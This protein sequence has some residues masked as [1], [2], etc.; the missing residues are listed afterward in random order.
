[1]DPLNALF[2]KLSSSSSSASLEQHLRVQNYSSAAS[3]LI[4]L[5]EREP[6]YEESQLMRY[7]SLYEEIQ[8]SSFDKNLFEKFTFFLQQVSHLSAAKCKLLDYIQEFF[9]FENCSI[10]HRLE[11]NLFLHRS[12][13]F[14]EIK[15]KIEELLLADFR[16]LEFFQIPFSGSPY[17]QLRESAQKTLGESAFCLNN[18][19]RDAVN[20]GFITLP[21]EEQLPEERELFFGQQTK[22]NLQKFRE[23]FE[24]DFRIHFQG[25]K[26][27]DPNQVR[28]F[29]RKTYQSFQDTFLTPLLALPLEILKQ[30]KIETEWIACGSLA[31]E[32]ITLG[33]DFEGFIL[34][35]ESSQIEMYADLLRKISLFIGVE[36]LSAGQT[37]LH[38][39]LAKKIPAF[40]EEESRGFCIDAIPNC[41]TSPL[42]EI[43]QNF[44]LAA[45]ALITL[46]DLHLLQQESA[47]LDREREKLSQIGGKKRRPKQLIRKLKILENQS[48]EAARIRRLLQMLQREAPCWE[49]FEREVESIKRES[50]PTLSLLSL[51]KRLS[52]IEEQVKREESEELE[53]YEK[54]QEELQ[55]LTSSLESEETKLFLLSCLKTKTVA[56]TGSFSYQDDLQNILREPIEGGSLSRGELKAKEALDFLKE[57]IEYFGS[58]LTSKKVKEFFA[59]EVIEIKKDIMQPLFYL[60]TTLAIHFGLEKTNTLDIVEELEKRE[61]CDQDSA[62]LLKRA[63][64]AIYMMRVRLRFIAKKSGD[65][66]TRANLI[67]LD[68]PR[69]LQEES[70]WIERVYLFVLPSLCRSIVECRGIPAKI[71]LLAKL[72]SSYLGQIE[73]QKEA[74]EL[75]HPMQKYVHYLL[76]T[77]QFTKVTSLYYTLSQKDCLEPLREVVYQL[78]TAYP[79]LAL[80]PIAHHQTGFRYSYLEQYQE[81]NRRLSLLTTEIPPGWGFQVKIETVLWERNLI[82]PPCIENGPSPSSKLQSRYLKPEYVKQLFDPSFLRAVARGDLQENTLLLKRQYP[83]SLHRVVKVQTAEGALHFKERPTHAAME[84]AIVSL[85][86]RCFGRGVV[87]SVMA[88]VELISSNGESFT[89]AVAISL[90]QEGELLSAL[91][92][93]PDFISKNRVDPEQMT[94]QLIGHVMILPSDAHGSNLM[95]SQG[96]LVS[97]DLE[98]SFIPMRLDEVD[99]ISKL[100]C[101]SRVSF[102]SELFCHD[103]IDHLSKEAMDKFQKIQAGEMLFAW[104]KELSA[105]TEGWTELFREEGGLLIHPIRDPQDTVRPARDVCCAV[106]CLLP[107]GTAAR[108]YRQIVHL[109]AVFKKTDRSPTPLSLLEE[110]IVCWDSSSDRIGKQIAKRYQ[111]SKRV[112][113]GFSRSPH[114][115]LGIVTGKGV[116]VSQSA[117]LT[118]HQLLGQIPN[119]EGLKE[120]QRS[121]Q[122]A[123]NELITIR[124]FYEMG[125]QLIYKGSELT[126]DI[127]QTHHL[128]KD[129]QRIFLHLLLCGQSI[130]NLSLPNFSELD[131]QILNQLIQKNGSTLRKLDLRECHNVTSTP[132]IK[133]GYYLSNLEELSLSGRE[134]SDIFTSTLVIPKLPLRLPKLKKLSIENSPRMK[135]F[136]VEVPHLHFL[137]VGNGIRPELAGDPKLRGF[138]S[139]NAL[140]KEIL[141]FNLDRTFLKTVKIFREE[142]DYDLVKF[143]DEPLEELEVKIGKLE[144]VSG[145]GKNLHFIKAFSQ[146]PFARLSIESV[147]FTIEGID[148]LKNLV[149]AMERHNMWSKIASSHPEIRVTFDKFCYKNLFLVKECIDYLKLFREKNFHSRVVFKASKATTRSRREDEGAHHRL[150]RRNLWDSTDHKIESKRLAGS[151]IFYLEEREDLKSL[152]ELMSAYDTWPKISPFHVKIYLKLDKSYEK[153]GFLERELVEDLQPFIKYKST[154]KI[155]FDPYPW[156]PDSLSLRPS[157]PPSS[158]TISKSDIEQSAGLITPEEFLIEINPSSVELPAYMKDKSIGNF[159]EIVPS[160]RLSSLTLNGSSSYRIR[161]IAESLADRGEIDRLTIRDRY[162]PFPSECEN[163]AKQLSKVKINTLKLEF[164]TYH[165]IPFLPDLTVAHLVIL[166]P[167]FSTD[168]VRGLI[169]ILPKTNITHLEFTAPFYCLDEIQSYIKSTLKDEKVKIDLLCR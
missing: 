52:E 119:E 165:F 21:R 87:P 20:R 50:D 96:Q 115:R 57:Q 126:I 75:V 108:L 100:L 71:D 169:E 22:A 90:T 84:F 10:Y 159:A 61:L 167:R 59:Q 129:K 24:E 1:M 139:H 14:K 110:I 8:H 37:S 51:Q 147:S 158:Q 143:I 105:L 109:Q 6:P 23:S 123:L 166:D 56:S 29:Q 153:K 54:Q 120:L 74:Q 130:V 42:R 62:A 81:L 145:F 53:R 160:L 2:Q 31:R 163:M 131:D 132:L 133:N 164:N 127:E 66:A 15:Q 40:K 101:D 92:K 11:V 47:L 148:Q 33:S 30:K 125:I 136:F 94:E 114:E 80:A 60:I 39:S 77:E 134:F 89:T 12:E 16:K 98:A 113:L 154:I 49:E 73:S 93:E 107:T 78:S 150:M 64:A 128:E 155:A 72:K 69:L 67:D 63:V 41:M 112:F 7:C 168:D 55:N 138:F 141:G 161:E 97:F 65:Q 19:I 25:K 76:D 144:M 18:Q 34:L 106:P 135:F 44:P 17:T 151:I 13:F 102:V 116:Q 149:N 48:K 58:P 88:K 152:A 3:E 111:Q 162:F 86:Y 146:A 46:E 68:I 104:L 82:P 36:I 32:E 4:F 35:K 70:V 38:P 122:D 91:T 156:F 85:F 99:F 43:N 140:H 103:F 45:I 118:F 157:S 5:L 9:L 83:T 137:K 95:I 117:S 28:S 121:P 26:N 124:C 27:F 142:I 79:Q